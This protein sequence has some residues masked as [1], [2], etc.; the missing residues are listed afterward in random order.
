M[1]IEEFNP[2][3]MLEKMKEDLEKSISTPS[4]ATFDIFS[5]IKVF[6][7]IAN[8]ARHGKESMT[9]MKQVMPE[10]LQEELDNKI[11]LMSD[12]YDA[13]KKVCNALWGMVPICQR[14][15]A[16]KLESNEKIRDILAGMEEE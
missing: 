11:Q 8:S 12:M 10:E 2:H 1:N 13:S 9:E 4:T 3:E 5:Y 7:E 14:L 15:D 6:A 16:A